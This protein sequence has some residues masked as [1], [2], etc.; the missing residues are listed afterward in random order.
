MNSTLNSTV[1]SINHDNDIF[2][3]ICPNQARNIDGG[4]M[5]GKFIGIKSN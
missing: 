2:S 4:N 5:D 1:T 3:L